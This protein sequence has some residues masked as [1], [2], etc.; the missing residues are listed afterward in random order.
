MTTYRVALAAMGA[1]V[2]MCDDDGYES[3]LQSGI[4]S[5]SSAQKIADR[6]T[7]REAEARKLSTEVTHA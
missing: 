4:K 2:V 1:C 5:V 7:K 3:V 6:W